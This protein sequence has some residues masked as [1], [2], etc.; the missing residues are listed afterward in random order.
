MSALI[1][2]GG[3]VSDELL[4]QEAKHADCIIAADRGLEALE[5]IER[6]PHII[7]GDFDSASGETIAHLEQYASQGVRVVRLNPRKDDTDTEAALQLAFAHSTGDII[8]LGGTGSRLDHVLGNISIL[9]QGLER[10]R[11]VFLQDAHNRIRI[12]DGNITLHRKEL[13]GPFISLFPYGDRV[14]GVTL[15]GFQ[16]PLEE[17]TLEGYTSLGVSNELVDE[18]GEIYIRQGALIVIEARD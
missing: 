3:M 13:Y 14:E 5:R 15:Q 10:G 2:A 8:I 12:I 11:R 16:Y 7:V 1:V 18:I 9:G 6:Y 17:A 4:V